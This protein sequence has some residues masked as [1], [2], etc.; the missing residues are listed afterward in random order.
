MKLLSA[1]FVCLISLFLFGT[2]IGQ[3]ISLNGNVLIVAGGAPNN[4]DTGG[5]NK[6]NYLNNTV[7]SLQFTTA[8]LIP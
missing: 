5:F 1:I 2:A 3:V 7:N 4:F 6:V 8:H